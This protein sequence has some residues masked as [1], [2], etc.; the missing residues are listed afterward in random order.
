[1][2]F[3]SGRQ[4]RT[5]SYVPFPMHTPCFDIFQKEN[6][7]PSTSESSH[8]IAR[9]AGGSCNQ[10]RTSVSHTF[11][12]RVHHV[13][14]DKD[15]QLDL[16]RQVE[17]LRAA[18]CVGLDSK[19]VRMVGNLDGVAAPLIAADAEHL[20]KSDLG[21]MAWSSFLGSRCNQGFGTGVRPGPRAPGIIISK[22]DPPNDCLCLL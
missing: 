22:D 1:M 18:N 13:K 12:T 7:F 5:P 20:S 6:H 3:N 2:G 10:I 4:L 11:R 17:V 19:G 8:R 14:R 16:I 15:V 21:C 9:S